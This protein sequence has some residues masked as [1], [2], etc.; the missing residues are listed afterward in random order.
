VDKRRDDLPS[1][2]NYYFSTLYYKRYKDFPKDELIKIE[3][4]E[5]FLE[6]RF[7]KILKKALNA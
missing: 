5:H 4:K 7:M 1:L 6:D 3:E 2:L